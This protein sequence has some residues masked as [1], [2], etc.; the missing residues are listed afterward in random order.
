[1][2]C[3]VT[4]LFAV[5]A[6]SG[7]V[8]AQ[9]NVLVIVADDLGVDRV[10]AYG[11][12]HDPGHTPNID[13]LAGA[14][15]LFRNA[16]SNPVCSPTR[17][18]I[19][20]GRY[21]FRTL[22]GKAIRPFRKNAIGLDLSELTVPE[23][24]GPGYQSGATGK[25]HLSAASDGLDH[26]RLQGFGTFAGSLWNL[27]ATQSDY[28]RWHKVVNGQ[29]TLSHTYATTDTTNDA[30]RLVDSL[31]E[32]WFLYVAYNAPHDPVHA[33]PD[34]LHTFSLSGDPLDSPVIHTKAMIE[35]LDTELG[36][37]LTH[38][39]QDRTTIMFLGDNGTAKVASEAPFL[40]QHAKATMYEG[41]LNVPLIVTGAGVVP[42]ECAAL[43]HT[44]D[45]FA[46]V[47]ELTGFANTSKD[48]V[49]LVPYLRGDP[50]PRREYV[51]SERFKPNGPGPYKVY[52]QAVRGSRFKL[53]RR[54]K[55][56]EMYDLATDP[57]EQIDILQQPLQT[58]QQ[59]AAYQRLDAELARILAS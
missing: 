1:M 9:G 46:T 54:K 5:T 30:I 21:S 53:I 12:H 10:A 40:P 34:W 29:R 26:P 14:G 45:V 27:K 58:P 35:A 41:G 24:L 13:R 23:L 49:S 51:Y 3:L 56:E 16:W 42:G 19:L 43:V 57:F 59:E 7:S 2:R 36:R 20:T 37:L 39:D 18:T 11:E 50:T 4:C 32:P 55:G 6:A 8:L 17:A 31:P 15:V 44:V 28:F 52:E 38:V 47:A 48:S 25:W 33:P 22:I